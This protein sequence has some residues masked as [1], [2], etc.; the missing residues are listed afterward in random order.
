VLSASFATLE[1]MEAS[2]V[3]QMVELGALRPQV[4]S[5]VKVAGCA[6]CVNENKLAHGSGKKMEERC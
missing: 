5:C 1:D 3:V 4:E 6:K 2:E